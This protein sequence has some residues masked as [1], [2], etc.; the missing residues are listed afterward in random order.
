MKLYSIFSYCKRQ[1]WPF[2]N[3]YSSLGIVGA[4][5]SHRQSAESCS[6]SLDPQISSIWF[7]LSVK[8]SFGSPDIMVLVSSTSHPFHVYF[9]S[10]WLTALIISKMNLKLGIHLTLTLCVKV[11]LQV[12]CLSRSYL[13]RASLNNFSKRLCVKCLRYFDS[14]RALLDNLL[15]ID[16]SYVTRVRI[17][18][19]TD[20]NSRKW[21]NSTQNTIRGHLSKPASSARQRSLLQIKSYL[22]NQS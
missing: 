10:W 21:R 3:S 2:L 7:W 8:E 1:L 22:T 20:A 11:Q 16:P 5:I 17:I 4:S 6:H 13:R 18:D 14:I 9:T 15:G 12:S 19:P